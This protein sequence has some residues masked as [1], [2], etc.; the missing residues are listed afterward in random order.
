[1]FATEDYGRTWKNITN[2]LP[3]GSTFVVREDYKNPDLLFAGTSAA[4]YVSLNRGDSWTRF[5][6]D[7]PTVEIHDLYI[8][9][10]DGDLIAGTHGR[11]AWILDNITALQEYTPEVMEKSA[12]LFSVRPATIWNTPTGQYPY[13]SDKMFRG[14]NPPNEPA[15]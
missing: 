1:M 9:P 2:N 11:G 4:V 14:D 3:E 5:M 13:Q 8:H 15:I 12:H 6:N 7:M 10:R